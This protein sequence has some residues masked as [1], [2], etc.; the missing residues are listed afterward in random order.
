[1]TDFHL[2]GNILD[3]FPVMVVEVEQEVSRGV[4]LQRTKCNDLR[5]LCI[6]NGEALALCDDI[7]AEG[8]IL[9]VESRLNP[10]HYIIYSAFAEQSDEQSCKE[11]RQPA[12]LSGFRDVAFAAMF[13]LPNLC[14]NEES[15]EE[16]E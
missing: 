3:Y 16:E 13:P 11:A 6:F 12:S 8:Q 9:A 1:M 5:L 10:I 15:V 7:L 2:I 14:G 4:D